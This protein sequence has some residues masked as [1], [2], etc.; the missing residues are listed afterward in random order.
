MHTSTMSYGYSVT[1]EG[2]SHYKCRKYLVLHRY[3]YFYICRYRFFAYSSHRYTDMQPILL[4]LWKKVGGAQNLCMKCIFITNYVGNVK[5]TL[6]AKISPQN[7][8]HDVMVPW[9][10]VNKYLLNVSYL[11]A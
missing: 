10:G 9:V 11:V 7:Q 2:G 5:I 3:V 6:I 1:H 8:H 4:H